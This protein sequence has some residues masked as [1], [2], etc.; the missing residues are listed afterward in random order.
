MTLANLGNFLLAPEAI[1]AYYMPHAS[2]IPGAA[3][4]PA[5]ASATMQVMMVKSGNRYRKATPAEIAE[6]AGFHAREAM[7][8]ERPSLQT[9]TT[10]VSYL[11]AMYSGQDY[12]TFTVLYLDSQRRLIAAVELFRGSI[13]TSSVYPREVVKECLWR[14]AHS[15]IFAHNHPSGVARPSA[16]DQSIT[17][18]LVQALALIDVGVLDHIIIGG[19]GSWYSMAQ[20]GLL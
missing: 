16:A 19:P 8:R 12:E 15:V 20:H 5:K 3:N 4:K 18:R 11:F 14:G 9:P 2:R 1:S 17:A 13:D 10:A 7:N 6:A